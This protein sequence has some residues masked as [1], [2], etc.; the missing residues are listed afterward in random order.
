MQLSDHFSLEELIAT[1]HREFDNTPNA[2]E[3]ANLTRLAAMLEQV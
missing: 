2:S 3:M 1:S